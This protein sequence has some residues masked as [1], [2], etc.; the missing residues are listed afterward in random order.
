MLSRLKS[1]LRITSFIRQLYGLSFL[2]FILLFTNCKVRLNQTIIGKKIE[3]YEILR[4]TDLLKKIDKLKDGQ[5]LHLRPN[6]GK[7]SEIIQ[8]NNNWQRKNN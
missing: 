5:T 3:N 8:I 1:R 2:L 6:S 4:P 7:G